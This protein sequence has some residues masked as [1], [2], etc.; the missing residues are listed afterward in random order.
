[1]VV[2]VKKYTPQDLQSWNQFVVNA[3]NSTFLFTRGYVDYHQH[4][5]T[6]HS[7]M[8]YADGNL[9]ALFIANETGDTIESHSGL[10][11]GGLILEK[12][13]RLERVIQY[14]YHLTKYYS[15]RF[16]RII[17]KCVPSYF[18]SLPAHEDLY[19][20]F[21]LN[22]KLFRRDMSMVLDMTEPAPVKRRTSRSFKLFESGQYRIVTTGDPD[23][24]WNEILIPNL[25]DRFGA[26]PVHTVAEMKLLKEQFPGNIMIF[27]VYDNQQVIAGAVVYVMENTAH[28]Q[29]ISANEHGREADAS[30]VLIHHLITKILAGKTWFGFGTSNT[31]EGRKLN[32][33][34]AGW[35]E[36]FGAKAFPHDFYE[37]E[38]ANYTLLKDYE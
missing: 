32:R 22:A 30:G 20:L 31:D 15:N 25:K 24:F 33:G 3:K 23:K 12:D 16:K 36:G 6:D 26:G 21:L 29:Y 7:L 5:F 8:I 38:T 35:K 19:A 28:L 2:Q 27:E 4:K 18:Q 14:F 1:M 34:L 9:S 10:T 37:I 11:Y 13:A 17:Y